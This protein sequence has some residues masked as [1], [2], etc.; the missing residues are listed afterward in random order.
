MQVW[1]GKKIK[2][3]KEKRGLTVKRR[4]QPDNTGLRNDGSRGGSCY[5]DSYWYTSDADEADP[6]WCETLF[7]VYH[8]RS[9]S[10]FHLTYWKLES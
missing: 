7:N 3:S 5:I 2:R 9:G 1:N 10:I 6:I 4:P 8:R